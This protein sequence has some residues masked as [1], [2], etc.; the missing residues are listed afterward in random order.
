MEVI[1][2]RLVVMVALI[3]LSACGGGSKGQD[4]LVE[5]FPI[6][7]VK[8][9]IPVDEEQNPTYPDAR[10]NIAF[11]PGADLFVRA[12]AS[13]Q[14]GEVN[15]THSITRD[16]GNG[17][18]SVNSMGDVKDVEASYDG[19]KLIFAMRKPEI[20]DADPEDQPTWN[21]WE[22]HIPTGNLRR[23]IELDE[24]SEK[25]D[26]VAPYYLPDGRIVFTSTRQQRS[27]EVLTD[28]GKT[29][30]TTEVDREDIPALMLHVM[31]ADGTDIQQLTFSPKRDMD[32]IVRS[33]G[34]IVF[35][36]WDRNRLGNNEIN[37]Y[38]I[39]PDGTDLQL[40]YGS[41]SHETGTNLLDIQFMQPREYHDG[42]LLTIARPF[43]GTFGGGDMV[44]IDTNYFVDYGRPNKDNQGLSGNGQE[45]LTGGSVSTIVGPSAGGRYHSVYPLTDGSNRSLVSW[46][47]CRVEVDGKY[48]SCTQLGSIEGL[49]A[50]PPFY[51]LFVLN[52]GDNTKL[53]IIN[54]T[55]DIMITDVVAAQNRPYPPVL[56]AVEGDG[57][58]GV[59]HIRSVYD[60]DGTFNALGAMIRKPSVSCSDIPVTDMADISLDERPPVS[61]QEMADY[62]VIGSSRAR[63]LRIIKP[64]TNPSTQVMSNGRRNIARGVSN[65]NVH[66]FVDILGYAPIEP[67]GSVKVTVPAD[68]PFSFQILDSKGRRI[69]IASAQDGTTPRHVT[70][71]QVQS[72]ETLECNGCHLRNSTVTHGNK[73]AVASINSGAT[74]ERNYECMETD[75]IANV[76]ETMAETRI[77]HC[78]G[79]K[80]PGV[81]PS[82][83]LTYQ[84]IWTKNIDSLDT[85]S[86][87]SKEPSFEYLY[88]DI[89]TVGDL[90]PYAAGCDVAWSSNC[91]VTINYI[92]HIAPLWRKTGRKNVDDVAATCT[93]NG[94]HAPWDKDG[95]VA[96]P[97][98]YTD[99]PLISAIPTV[100][101]N[102]NGITTGTQIN[103]DDSAESLQIDPRDNQ[104]RLKSYQELFVQDVQQKSFDGTTLENVQAEILVRREDEEGNPILDE[105]EME[106]FDPVL[107]DILTSV[108]PGPQ[109]VLSTN[110]AISSTRFFN[111]MEQ[112]ST[113]VLDMGEPVDPNNKFNHTGAL[114]PAELKLISEWLD[115]GGQYYNNPFMVPEN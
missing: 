41:N 115:A 59:L 85:I 96:P 72:G 92:D 18:T 17:E 56:E 31:E 71:L 45:S 109:A 91:R 11:N 33:D 4:P 35:S 3:L 48:V 68:T 78:D 69:N 100:P 84:D 103:L 12:Y 111:A 14:A 77:R 76:G 110:G 27:K 75:M 37:L 70:W 23:V 22:Y 5:P 10:D 42:R 47:Q 61:P 13:S 73:K 2:K 65:E 88:S 99:N 38:S 6:A 52:H 114:S 80:C 36:R 62:G 105:N 26:D 98:P 66:S 81:N 43:E 25:G 28:E 63:F 24:F 49:E 55:E 107:I 51:G 20:E 9:P 90:K 89:Y 74:I 58:T 1:H 57:K 60:F 54:P 7:Y 102:V 34:K 8:R 94:C 79:K 93:N 29:G 46:T 40:M 53:P 67:D 86:V 82:L 112:D 39:N 95:N 83:N 44:L 104:N 87:F 15:V 30:F 108:D 64:L 21:I 97:E 16:L 32:P 113:V 101:D 19:T 50:A 106:I